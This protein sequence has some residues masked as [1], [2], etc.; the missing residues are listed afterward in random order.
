MKK[1]I[2]A[3]LCDLDGVI[4]K[5]AKLHARTWKT[6]FDIFLQERTKAT[7]TEYRLFDI[8][9]DYERYIDGK[10][11]LEGIRSYL[12]ARNINIPEGTSDDTPDT[13]SVNGLGK[14][15]NLLFHDLLEAVGVEVMFPSIRAIREWK[16][17]GIKIAVVSS[18][19]NCRPV[20]AAAGITDLFDVIVDGVTAI[21]IGLAGKPEP[22]AF[23]YASQKL[24]VDP[25]QAAV[26]EDAEV[27]IQAAIKGGF[28][29]A[30]GILNENNREILIQ[31]K[32]DVLVNNLEELFYTGSS[33]RYPQ[34]SE[35]LEQA[36]LCEDHIG[37][38]LKTKKA[39]LFFDYDGTLTPIVAHPEDALLS[40]V[41]REKLV[42]LAAL[43]PITIISGRD[44]DDVK[45]LVG[46]ENI[47]YAGSHG[48]DIEGPQH[49]TLQHSE[50]N[51]FIP[52]IKKIAMNLQQEL[53]EFN[54]IQIELKK[55]AVAVHYRNAE[56]KDTKKI[57]NRTLQLVKQN[58][59]LRTGEGKMVIEV[60]PDME[61]DKGKAMRWI[62]EKLHLN[63]SEFHHL[64]IGDDLTDEDAFKTLPENGTGILVGHHQN[65]TYA[66]FRIDNPEEINKLLDSFIRI[67]K[68]A[69]KKNK[70]L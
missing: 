45:K 18:S 46:I 48:F 8:V 20:L 21:E 15:K 4:T 9:S 28:G 56:Q 66:D 12:D 70:T 60:R 36:C 50:G 2:K 41:T 57:I 54:G 68:A 39:V 44:K 47:Y 10:P 53:K 62:S 3:I 63:R 24:K 17:N 42:E 34:N 11:R 69:K 29:L 6:L 16:G 51:S 67:I 59:G 33:L 38:E 25:G 23:I 26:A 19:K 52:L 7:H 37:K 65:P 13:I 14:K 30:V 27:G 22:D 35:K 58:P 61:W 1:P 43:V 55:F 31:S 49:T 40:T 32:A 5:T 64:Y